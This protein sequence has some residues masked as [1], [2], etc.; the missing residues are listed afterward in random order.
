MS[1]L[2]TKSDGGTEQ[3]DPAKLEHS[4]ELARATS[5]IRARVLAS[6]VH[7]LQPMMSTES[8]Y[9]RAF[10]ILRRDENLPVA[11]PYS[12]KRAIFALGPSGFPFEQFIAEILRGHGWRTMTGV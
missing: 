3:F 10:D 6:I 9:R 11:A 5:T 4:L 12:V 8:I 2:V 1:T 7:E